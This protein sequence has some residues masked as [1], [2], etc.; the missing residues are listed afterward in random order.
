MNTNMRTTADSSG[1]GLPEANRAMSFGPTRLRSCR[2]LPVGR[3]WS[4]N[5]AHPALVHLSLY[6]SVLLARSL[7]APSHRVLGAT[8]F[9]SHNVPCSGLAVHPVRGFRGFIPSGERQRLR[10]QAL[11][12]VPHGVAAVPI[13][14]YRENVKLCAASGNKTRR[15]LVN[16]TRVTEWKGST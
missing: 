2:R 6:R 13:G 12:G 3:R 16:V 5:T 1:P 11:R 15:S 10:R 8:P 9:R 7:L 14:P 4:S